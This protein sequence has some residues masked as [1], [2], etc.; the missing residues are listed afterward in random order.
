MNDD[1]PTAGCSCVVDCAGLHEIGSTKSN[2]LKTLY[3]DNLKSGNIG[4]PAIVWHEYKEL[5]EEEA[6]EIEPFVSRKIRITRKYQVGAARI[7][8]QKNSGFS[9]GPYDG[10]SDLYTAAIASIE[11]YILLTTTDQL[12][13]YDGMDCN[14]SD[15]SSW[16]DDHGKT[17]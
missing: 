14:V 8:D 2:N 16:A 15:L 1:T 13:E 17:N 7:A 10:E 4:V 9:R 11:D 3:L 6:V 12:R 5:Y